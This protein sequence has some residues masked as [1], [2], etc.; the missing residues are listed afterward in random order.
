M[1]DDTGL[2][3]LMAKQRAMAE[4]ASRLAGEQDAGR[5]QALAEELRRMGDELQAAAMALAAKYE[6]KTPRG[7]TEVVLT[8]AQRQR[9]RD[10][11]GVDMESVFLED[12][13][14]MTMR[15]MP[16]MDPRLIEHWALVEAERRKVGEEAEAQLRA[17]VTAVVDAIERQGTG[18]VIDQ[19]NQL[20]QDPN[21]AG[22]LLRKK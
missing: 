1:A 15:T 20:K 14:G 6:T 18:A 19:L 7:R 12:E 17:E 5:I 3:E 13:T 11:T 2:D 22:G 9:V 8:E 16:A 21:F 10:K 4:L